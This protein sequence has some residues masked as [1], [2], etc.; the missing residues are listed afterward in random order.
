MT[1]YGF[2]DLVCEILRARC[3]TLRYDEIGEIFD[4]PTL[5]DKPKQAETAHRLSQLAPTDATIINQLS[6]T[7]SQ[8]VRTVSGRSLGGISA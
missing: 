6:Q 8:Q 5:L 7:L 2:C 4:V 1:Q 3:L